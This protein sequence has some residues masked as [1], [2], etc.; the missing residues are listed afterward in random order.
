MKSKTESRQGP[1]TIAVSRHVSPGREADFAQ[2]AH[3]IGEAAARFPG[4]LGAGYIRPA[5]S[6]GEHTIVY[7]FD[8]QAHFD[9]WQD[10]D[11]RSGWIERSRELISGE[12]RV[13]MATGL[14]YWFH[15]PSCSYGTPPPV[16][17]Q[18]LLTWLGLYPTVLL[19]AYTVGLLITE[20]AVPLRSILTTAL[21]VL[22]MTW[23]V[24]PVVTRVFRRFLHPTAS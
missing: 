4:H 20:W 7:R 9:A 12:P 14:E 10:S 21:S 19:V 24:M 15:D 3:D 23:A 2:W 16:W 13:Q 11:E 6:A 17:K 8:T 5:D 22:I 1:V 18:A